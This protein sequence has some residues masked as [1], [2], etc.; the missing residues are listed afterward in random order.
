MEKK[1]TREDKLRIA[2]DNE[3]LVAHNYQLAEVSGSE[4][5]KRKTCI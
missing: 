4:E 2:D 1:D 5:D 3:R